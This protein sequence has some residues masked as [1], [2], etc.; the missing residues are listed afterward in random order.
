MSDKQKSLIHLKKMNI[1]IVFAAIVM[2]IFFASCGKEKT[3]TGE[4]SEERD[5]MPAMITYDVETFISDS[6]VVR[7]KV[8][9]DEWQIFDRRKPSYW[10]FEKGMYM[11][12]FDSLHNVEASIKADTAYYYDRQRLWKL[13]GN[14]EIENQK[15]ER[16][17]TELLYWNQVNERV[18]SDRFIRIEQPDRIIEGE[19]FDSNQQ[20][21][22][23]QIH[24]I[25][26]IFYVDEEQTSAQPQ[27]ATGNDDD[28]P[29]SAE[30][31]GSG[32]KIDEKVKLDEPVKAQ[33]PIKSNETKRSD[34]PVKAVE[35]MQLQQD[36][37]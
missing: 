11:E 7:Y 37:N 24:N 8:L 33:E 14:V 12:Q 30:K 26:G 27:S 2:L 15:G 3:Y 31:S 20:L 13:I 17:N 36:R 25:K 21:T 28:N 35:M 18:Y 5:S 1:T 29:D 16:F 9:A 23:Y 19:G 10:A 6:G 32:L 34:E 22:V 4:A